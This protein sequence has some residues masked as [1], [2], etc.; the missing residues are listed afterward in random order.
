MLI[1][2]FLQHCK[3]NVK[4]ANNTSKDEQMMRK[5][6]QTHSNDDISL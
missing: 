5:I 6:L 3:F 4:Q 1:D 2:L